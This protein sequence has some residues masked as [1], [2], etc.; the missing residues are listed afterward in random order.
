MKVR[1]RYLM[2]LTIAW[3]AC[4][5]LALAFYA[6]ILRPQSEYRRELEAQVGSYKQRYAVAVQAAKE[7]DQKRL[8]G[9]VEDLRRRIGDFVLG[10]EEAPTLAFRIGELAN[11]AKL[12]SFGMKPTNRS[13]PN[14]PGLE[15]LG[16][17]RVNLSFAT[18]FR[19]FAAFL[20]T[21][22]RHRPVVFVETFAISRPLENDTQPQ[23]SMELA[24]LVEKETK[25]NE[26]PVGVP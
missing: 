9:E 1:S 24:V 3:G 6:V 26:P 23:A 25:P 12:E 10:L 5:L 2:V 16:E 20:N 14:G 11:G 18:G 15:Q 4:L 19:R 22:E 7:K 21:L 13:M 8:A 17:K